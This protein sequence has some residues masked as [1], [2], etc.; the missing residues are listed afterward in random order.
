MRAA[1][2]GRRGAE[3]QLADENSPWNSANKAGNEVHLHYIHCNRL[4]RHQR[5]SDAPSTFPSRK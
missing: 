5:S 2:N 1:G 4:A 3:E